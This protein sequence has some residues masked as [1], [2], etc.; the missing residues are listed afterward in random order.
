MHPTY[1]VTRH[2]RDHDLKRF[3]KSHLT[4]EEAQAWCRN[5]ET[6]SSTCSPETYLIEE[7]ERFGPWFDAYEEEVDCLI[8][9]YRTE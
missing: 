9:R 3:M 5:K 2:Y 1:R 4:L 7:T 6:S 8:C